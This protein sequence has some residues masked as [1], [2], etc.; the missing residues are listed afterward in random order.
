[1]EAFERKRPRDVAQLGRV[2]EGENSR[3][4][5]VE[6]AGQAVLRKR[7]VS[8]EAVDDAS[9]A[10][11]PGGV[12]DPEDIVEGIARVL[13]RTHVDHQRQSRGVGQLD[14]C[15]QALLLCLAWFVEVAQAA[16]SLQVHQGYD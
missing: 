5:D 3:E 8:G 14:L 10:L 6:P 16:A 11:G 12:K 13:A 2:L 7:Q 4:R 1:M 9:G 15:P